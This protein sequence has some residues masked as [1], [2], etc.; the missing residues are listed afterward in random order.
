VDGSTVV[1]DADFLKESIVEPN[2]TIIEG[3]SGFMPAYPLTDEQLD[4]L[5]A[6][7]RSLS[8]GAE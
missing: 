5:V 6:Y 8:S 4:H 3:Y 1:V 2:A 7:T